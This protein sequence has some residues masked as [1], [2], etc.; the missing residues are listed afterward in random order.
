MTT[1]LYL[2]GK[3][4][5]WVQHLICL[6]LL[7]CA[8]L[9]VAAQI[10]SPVIHPDR[11]VTLNFTVPEADEVVVC[12]DIPNRGLRLTTGFGS[13]RFHNDIEMTRKNDTLWTY[14][15]QALKPD[16][17]LYYYEVD[18]EDDGDSLDVRNPNV[19][20]DI[21]KLFSFFIVP[22]DTADYYIDSLVPHGTVRKIWHPSS[23]ELTPQRRMTVYT[24]P[25]YDTDTLRRYPVLYLLH[26]TG[27]DEDSWQ[28]CGRAMQ[29][30]DNMLAGKL[31]QPMIVVMP[32]GD[33]TA[34]AAPDERIHFEDSEPSH[35]PPTQY[36]LF[37]A[38]FMHDVVGYVD[39]HYRTLPDK[40]HRA[41]AGLSLGGFHT[42]FI[43]VNNPSSFDY[44]GLFS[45]QIK[46]NGNPF[47]KAGIRIA[48]GIAS[49]IRRLR[50]SF[51]ENGSEDRSSLVD[52]KNGLS[53][54]DNLDGKLDDLFAFQ[55]SL[56]YM[57]VGHDDF[58][59]HPVDVLSRDLTKKSYKHIY[60]K[61]EGGHTWNNWRRYLVDF[62]PRLFENTKQNQ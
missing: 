43:T 47:A 22:G 34:D 27:G 9:P 46:P 16:M 49:Q 55:P 30:L 59:Q 48:G 45:P 57:A 5:T 20:R 61:T 33:T 31:I 50:S 60:R 44:I 51:T 53:Q 4:V 11:T 18:G 6:A 56:F 14:T 28:D 37:E 29:I 26:G 54:Y 42:L 19:V 24:P 7:L 21:D 39:T 40:K 38:S 1:F 2:L 41:I 36:G 10:Q 25:G 52:K 23:L 3:L 17:Y 62:L 32:N 8:V 12:G 15:T 13:I 35:T 58:V